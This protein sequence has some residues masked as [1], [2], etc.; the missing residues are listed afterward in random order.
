MRS[1]V[2]G[3]STEAICLGKVLVV[4]RAVIVETQIA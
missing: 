1:G 3:V 4:N 2:M